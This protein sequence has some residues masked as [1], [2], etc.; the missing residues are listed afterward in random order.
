MANYTKY[1][2]QLFPI[3]QEDFIL[4]MT[5]GHY[6]RVAHR[7][8]CAAL[9]YYGIRVSELLRA[10]KE[11]FFLKNDRVYFDVGPRLKGGR[12]TAPLFVPMKRPFVNT[13]WSCVEE[14]KK[15]KR[16]WPFCRAT[17]WNVTDRA[18]K[19]YPH[20]FRLSRITILLQKGFTI[21]EVK[22][23]TGHKS[24]RSL[25]FYAGTVSIEKM[26]EA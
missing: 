1:G 9:F 7:A 8:F 4:S 12:H 26:G 24:L 2:K 23:W 21:I 19:T 25:D 5:E 13:I 10:K 22:S 20:H 18:F 14:T 11:Q 3:A 15:K 17:A 6:V 16:V